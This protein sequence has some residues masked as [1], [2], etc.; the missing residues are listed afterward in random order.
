MNIAILDGVVIAVILISAILAMI[1][2]FV[3]E[4]LSIA[5][6][7]AAAI[8]AYLFYPEVLPYVTQHVTTQETLA[9]AL[10]AAA[11]FLVALIVVS[12]ITM[13]ISDFVMDSPVGVLDRLLGLAFGAARGLLLVVVATIVFNYVL[14]EG[15]RP[16]WVVTSVSYPELTELGSQLLA[17]FPED[18][19]TAIRGLFDETDNAASTGAAAPAAPTLEPQQQEELQQLFDA[20]DNGT[21][22][23]GATG[24]TD[25]GAQN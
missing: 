18:P 23:G 22:T 7:V 6:W 21:T 3:R 15:D 4:V 25:T 11:I 14:D 12:I 1:R 5:A 10:S 9:I 13:K 2:G 16:D 19:E 8:L 17:L 24:G 20:Q